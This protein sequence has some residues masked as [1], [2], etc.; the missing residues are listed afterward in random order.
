MSL[1]GGLSAVFSLL[2]VLLLA[3]LQL[4]N[5]ATQR[6]AAERERAEETARLETAERE[7]AGKEV[8]EHLVEKMERIDRQIRKLQETIDE[9]ESEKEQVR[10]Q[11]ARDIERLKFLMRKQGRLVEE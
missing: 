3:Q 1:A 6:E 2:V 9:K 10:K 11:Y 4:A 5:Q 8:P 7:R